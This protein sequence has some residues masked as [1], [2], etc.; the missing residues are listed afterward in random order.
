[1][2]P[3]LWLAPFAADKRSDVARDH[4]E[5]VIRN[6]GGVAANSSHCGKFFY[7]LDATNP[8]VRAHVHE[9]VRRAV[10]DWNFN[11]LKIDF[12]YAACL[13]GNGRYD[14][15]ISRAQAMH[16][17]LKTIRD[18]AGPDVFLIGCGCPLA[19][20][21]GYVDAMRISA[22]TGPTWYAAPPLPWWDNGTLP[23]LRSMVRNSIARAPLGHRW[24]HND[25]DCLMLGSHTSLTDDEVAS[26]ATVV[27]MTC[28]MLL[29][30]DDLPKVS[31]S[32]LRIVSKIFPLTGVTAAVLDL[33]ST[34]DG[35]PSLMRLWCTDRYGFFDSFSEDMS[36]DERGTFDHNAKA[37]FFAR[38]ASYHPTMDVRSHNNERLRSCIHLTKGMG[39]WMVVSISNWTDLSTVVRIPPLALRSPLTDG[40]G[41]DD[42]MVDKQESEAPYGYH[43][44]GFWSSKYSWLAE[45]KEDDNDDSDHTVCK[46]LRP[47]ET[48]LFHIKRVTHDM[49]QYVGKCFC[50]TNT[51]IVSIPCASLLLLLV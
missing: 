29:L 22:D 17:A 18:A 30:S 16:L 35:L 36:V 5:W 39:T 46:K 20:G 26:A 41:N 38:K 6:D 23:A 11:V 32:R 2:R 25:P 47:H 42:G 51:F 21:I 24:W 28:G 13:S 15:S 44:F 45:H 33:H 9:A 10:H 7:G 4:P 40:W 8:A 49:P 14:L 48:E 27:A 31:D 1:M 37:T 50:L 43:V 34:N 19:S 3:G 12:L